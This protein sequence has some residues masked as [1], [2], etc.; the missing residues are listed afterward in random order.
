MMHIAVS[1]MKLEPFLESY[2]SVLGCFPDAQFIICCKRG[3]RQ[4]YANAISEI[5]GSGILFDQSQ[6]DG[7]FGCGASSPR[8]NS[9]GHK[10]NL[11]QLAS[12]CQDRKSDLI[13]FDEDIC[14]HHDTKAK[15]DAA[16]NRYDLVQGGFEGSAGNY[17][18]AMVYFF[19][20]LGTCSLGEPEYAEKA[21]QFLRGCPPSPPKPAAL[22]G[23][24]GGNLGVSPLLKA[25]AFW[26]PMHNYRGEDHFFEFF[27]RYTFPS[28]RFM[29]MATGAKEIPVVTHKSHP[30]EMGTFYSK[31]VSE[32]R[33]SIV[34]KYMY[35]MTCR[36]IPKIIAARH[37]LVPLKEFDPERICAETCEEAA[38]GKI[39]IAA[40]NSLGKPGQH[41]GVEE[42]LTKLASL[43]KAD[44]FVPLDE[45]QGEWDAFA[46]ERRTMQQISDAVKE[47]GRSLQGE[48]GFKA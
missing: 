14:P 5:G 20:F 1:T 34:E 29:D 30:G 27:S 8:S 31:F 38:L 42:I 16:F 19:E 32:V 9:L 47:L 4:S 28:M 3:D 35:Y 17:I 10:R 43:S 40:E 21:E 15:Y 46:R 33:S 36:K 39:A 18:Y 24:I 7:F 13:F 41:K 22:G 12:T 45:L 48:F 26:L 11:L 23:A 2:R 6:A 37:V 44:M 25:K